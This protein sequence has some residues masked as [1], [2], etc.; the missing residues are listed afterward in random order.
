MFQV[1]KDALEFYWFNFA[2]IC[3][4]FLPIYILELCANV[5]L[6]EF[7]ITGSTNHLVDLL[8]FIIAFISSAIYGA[9]LIVLFNS[10]LNRQNLTPGQCI[11]SGLMLFHMFVTMKF[12]IMVLSFFGF[13]LFII[14]GIF[15]AIRLSLAQFY[16]V[17]TNIPPIKALEKSFYATKGYTMAIFNCLMVSAIPMLVVSFFFI[18]TYLFKIQPDQEPSLII[19][20]AMDVFL[21]FYAI[22]FSILLFRIFCLLNS[23]APLRKGTFEPEDR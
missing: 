1:I 7:V 4:V 2:L 14:P 9:G 3:A 10:K 22:F 16:L 15:V 5:Y 23:G 6:K 18:N 20:I 21:Q 13:L 8:P 12:I 19:S 17:L 11:Y